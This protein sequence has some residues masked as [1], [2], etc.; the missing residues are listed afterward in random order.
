MAFERHGSSVCVS[1]AMTHG[2]T[3]SCRGSSVWYRSSVY[4][5][6]A[7]PLA[8]L[9]VSLRATGQG[10]TRG[11]VRACEADAVQPEVMPP[12]VNKDSAD[13]TRCARRQGAG[14]LVT[15]GSGTAVVTGA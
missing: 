8:A 14:T 7:M 4:R 10:W 11:L 6:R 5:R 13:I 15:T 2:G 9:P 12:V 1:R 3:S